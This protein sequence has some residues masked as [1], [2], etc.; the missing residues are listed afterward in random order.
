MEEQPNLAKIGD[1]WDDDTV[2]KIV[3][4]LTE[5]QDMFPTNFSELKGIL[6][7]LGVM[8]ITLKP[9]ARLVK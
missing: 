7:D 3:E 6:G 2:G 5:Y 1:Y 9:D 4:L 8:K